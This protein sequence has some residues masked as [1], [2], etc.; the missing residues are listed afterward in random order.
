[1]RRSLGS[2]GSNCSFVLHTCISIGRNNHGLKSMWCYFCSK[3]AISATILLTR[4]GDFKK[5]DIRADFLLR[6]SASSG[7]KVLEPPQSPP[8]PGLWSPLST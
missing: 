8:W 2:I 1:M 3:V 5:A 7:R 6:A 4:S